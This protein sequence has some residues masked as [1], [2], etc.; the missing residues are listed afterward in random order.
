MTLTYIVHVFLRES[1]FFQ[2]STFLCLYLVVF[3][4]QIDVFFDEVFQKQPHEKSMS[5]F[6]GF[7]QTSFAIFVL[8]NE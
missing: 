8:G 4:F 7:M 2:F 6:H 1:D 3:Y 5:L